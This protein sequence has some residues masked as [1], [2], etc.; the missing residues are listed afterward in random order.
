MN[1]DLLSIIYLLLYVIAWGIMFFYHHKHAKYFGPCSLIMLLYFLWSLMAFILYNSNWF[2]EKYYFDLSFFPF[3]YLF[4]MIVIALW[5]CII[6]ER[7]NVE[8]IR[9]PSKGL[10]YV[11]F[12]IY[13]IATLVS[14]PEIIQ[15]IQDNL[16]LLLTD[17]DAGVEIYKEKFQESGKPT[18]SSFIGPFSA[19][20]NL[21]KDTSVFV[22]FYYLTL[23]EKKKIVIFT[24]I[25]IFLITMVSSVA[26]GGRTKFVLLF[27]SM[28]ISYFTF[29]K[30]MDVKTY[31]SIK[32]VVFLFI[33]LVSIPFMALTFSR[34]GFRTDNG[35]MLGGIVDYSGQ[36]PLVFNQYALDAG[37]TRNGDRTATFFKKMLGLNP[38]EDFLEGRQKY[39]NMKLSD[40]DLSTFV[41]DFVLDYGPEFAFLLFVFFSLLFLQLTRTKSHVIG[42]HK[43]FLL[44]F[45]MCVCSQGSQYLFAYS[46]NDN[47]AI[48]AFVFM[49]VVFWIDGNCSHNKHKYI[50]IEKS[51]RLTI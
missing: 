2:P 18:L 8:Y 41:G 27:Y 31:H 24:M 20:R 47:I 30:Y 1:G 22:F 3:I 36:A 13:I 14:I 49:Y 40:H 26:A 6:Y 25:V 33:I 23:E 35:G 51:K 43:L 5:P 38:P 10:I 28:I 19:I 50:T 9:R 21:F 37:G 15:S 34:F 46:Y 45:I 11:F 48:V 12:T 16:F 17:E 4:V 44:Y 29:Y 7:S 39:S 42:F 32:K